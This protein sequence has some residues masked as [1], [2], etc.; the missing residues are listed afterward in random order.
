MF[1]VQPKLLW[2]FLYQL[3]TELGSTRHE[4]NS[5]RKNNSN[6]SPKRTRLS[7]TDREKNL[8]EKQGEGNEMIRWVDEE[9]G[10]FQILDPTGVA[11]EWGRVKNRKNMTYE[12]MSRALRYYYKMNIILKEPGKKL[13]YR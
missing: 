12:K 1:L 11:S 10:V 2:S 7:G 4:K 6:N 9:R 8:P 3:L 13:T 5:D